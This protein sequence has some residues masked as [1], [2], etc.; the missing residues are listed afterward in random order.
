MGKRKRDP[1]A[2]SIVGLREQFLR[3]GE[4]SGEIWWCGQIR[5]SLPADTSHQTSLQRAQTCTA[6]PPSLQQ[7]QLA[8]PIGK[9]QLQQKGGKGKD[10][11]DEASSSSHRLLQ[12]TQLKTQ[13]SDAFAKCT[14]TQLA[15]SNSALHFSIKL[16]RRLHFTVYALSQNNR[17]QANADFSETLHRG[18]H[19]DRRTV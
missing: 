19:L 9:H 4:E 6:Q 5:T 1:L 15:S 16:F 7:L 10:E 8:A 11:L 2:V 14:E 3:F 17:R 18:H 13:L 12:A